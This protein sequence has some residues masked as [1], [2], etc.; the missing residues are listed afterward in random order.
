M[1]SCAN[2]TADG[3]WGECIHWTLDASREETREEK[4]QHPEPRMHSALGEDVYDLLLLLLSAS[5][6]C[7][8]SARE[9]VLRS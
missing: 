7:V 9:S 4:Q 5:R 2:A 3:E 6:A 8:R 1:E